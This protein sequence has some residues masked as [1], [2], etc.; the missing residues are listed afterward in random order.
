MGIEVKGADHAV[1]LSM[2]DEYVP[3]TKREVHLMLDPGTADP[4]DGEVDLG[5]CSEGHVHIWILLSLPMNVGMIACAVAYVYA[6]ALEHHEEPF[7]SLSWPEWSDA[8]KTLVLDFERRIDARPMEHLVLRYL[9]SIIEDS[10]TAF[11]L[12]QCFAD[13]DVSDEVLELD[14]R[15][16]MRVPSTAKKMVH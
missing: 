8:L 4:E 14:R 11:A 5:L 10:S 2:L 16:N 7:Y 1:L 15:I 12:F 9:R 6:Y 3:L 13:G